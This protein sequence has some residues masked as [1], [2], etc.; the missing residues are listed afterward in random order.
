MRI[1]ELK[2]T[3]LGT[4]PS[5]Y[6]I[7]HIEKSRTFYELHIAIQ[8][9]FGWENY[10]MHEFRINDERIGEKEFLDDNTV[11]E[12]SNTL[13]SQKI[14]FEKQTFSYLYDFGDN[15]EHAIELVKFVEPKQTFYPKCIKGKRNAPPEDCGGIGGFLAFKEIMKNKKH[16]EHKEMIE[17]NDGPFDEE[18]F[19]LLFINDDFKHFDEIVRTSL[20]YDEED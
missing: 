19:S 13:L 1:L 5:V 18:Y 7:L 2:V 14:I 16:P 11:L 10:H 17:W 15:W 8:I 9:A 20:Q 12:G 6:R 3:L 4:K